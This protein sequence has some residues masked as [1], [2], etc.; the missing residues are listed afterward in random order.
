MPEMPVFW[1]I[2][3]RRV[4]SLK[5]RDPRTAFHDM[6]VFSS[7]NGYTFTLI[8]SYIKTRSM[9]VRYE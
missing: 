1:D 2:A 7:Q 6:N 8:L 4:V 5:V 9:E 3:V